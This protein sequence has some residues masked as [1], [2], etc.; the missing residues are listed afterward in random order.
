MKGLFNNKV[1]LYKIG[2]LEMKFNFDFYYLINC[3]GQILETKLGL[4]TY[5]F[6]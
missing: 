1:L 5:T 2:F 3:I 6:K 4:S